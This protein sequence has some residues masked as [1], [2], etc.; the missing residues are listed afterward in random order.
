[1]GLSPA[2]SP[3]TGVQQS[4]QRGGF[5]ERKLH[6]LCDLHKSLR[7][8][9]GSVAGARCF[10][11]TLPALLDVY[12]RQGQGSLGALPDFVQDK[13][14]KG[15]VFHPVLGTVVLAERTIGRCV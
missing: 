3:A 13:V 15:I 6:L 1:M 9:F 12:K 14:V 10:R 11:F 7:N 5:S 4:R 2:T 8:F